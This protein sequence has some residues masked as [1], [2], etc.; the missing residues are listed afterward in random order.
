[1]TLRSENGKKDGN[2]IKV[3]GRYGWPSILVNHSDLDELDGESL[4]RRQC[5]VC[6]HGVLLVCRNQQTF[7]LEAD[8]YCVY[9]GQHVEYLDIGRLRRMDMGLEESDE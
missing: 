4:F 6:E 8:D 2:G 5:P 3:L 9:C 1:M 7:E